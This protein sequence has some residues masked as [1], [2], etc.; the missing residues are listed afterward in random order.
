MLEMGKMSAKECIK[1]ARYRLCKSQKEFAELLD[2][3]KASVSLWESGARNPSF[4]NIKKIVDALRG[5]GIHY[6]YADFKND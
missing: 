1:N 6:E 2:L 4:P 3:N 5:H